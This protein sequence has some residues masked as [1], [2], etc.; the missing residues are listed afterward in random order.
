LADP[1]DGRRHRILGN[2]RLTRHSDSR[3][4]YLLGD[5]ARNHANERELPKAVQRVRR[6]FERLENRQLVS[7]LSAPE[8]S[9]APH[10]SV[11]S[12]T[13]IE[14]ATEI[15]V[16]R[17]RDGATTSAAQLEL[18]K[19]IFGLDEVTE[20]AL[21]EIAAQVAHANTVANASAQFTERIDDLQTQLERAE[22]AKAIALEALKDEQM[23]HELTRLDLDDAQARARW[24]TSRLKDVGD[25]E[26]NYLPVP[27][28][29]AE[30]RPEDFA[31]LLERIED[32]EGVQFTG[33]PE[34]V[35][36]LTAVDTNGSA[37][38]TAWDAVLAL[39]DY[40]RARHDGQP[41]SGLKQYLAETPAGYRT[42]PPGKFAETETAET[43]R[44]FGE[45]RL[46]PV[47]RSVDSSGFVYMRAHFK[48]A[49]IGIVT[50]RMHVFDAH[51]GKPMVYIGY[52][53]R[54]LPNTKTRSM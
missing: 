22:D 8:L 17:V 11:T 12:E 51:P 16:Q 2:E 33:D 36:S 15:T 14:A 50:P 34:Y 35:L 27:S 41:V 31:A 54:H 42:V 28:E 4:R 48:L 18:V 46:F 3:I 29:F 52:I 53:G 37:L 39:R 30:S 24:L 40:V 23:G 7:A 45:E 49:S 5:I 47:P 9:E 20:R 38:R 21:A 13:R 10:L 6:H 44:H 19:S 1:R 43:M 26:S 32:V 25:Y